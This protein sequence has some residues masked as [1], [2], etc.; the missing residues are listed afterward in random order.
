MIIMLK[1]DSL[2]EILGFIFMFRQEQ[3][4]YIEN[5]CNPPLNAN[6]SR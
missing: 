5:K 4:Y 1:N 3:C 2:V 6:N